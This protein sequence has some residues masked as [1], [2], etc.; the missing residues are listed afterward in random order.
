MFFSVPQAIL[1]LHTVFCFFSR[2]SIIDSK[3]SQTQ[4]NENDRHEINNIFRNIQP[5]CPRLV[6]FLKLNSLKVKTNKS[7]RV[8]RY[9]HEFVT[10][11]NIRITVLAIST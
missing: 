1:Q 2:D 9:F 7:S 10:F 3:D 8:V 4:T 11:P 5:R 6:T